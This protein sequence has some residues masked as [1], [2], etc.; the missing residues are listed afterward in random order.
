[1]KKLSIQDQ[2]KK[3]FLNP[4]GTVNKSTVAAF[5]TLLILLVQQVLAIFGAKFTG[6][7]S[8]IA[9]AINTVLAILAAAGFVEGSGEVTTTGG[10]KNAEVSAPEKEQTG[11]QGK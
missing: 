1:M 3:K 4:D 8:Q 10:E 6:D 7:W 9:G 11:V 2:V 5:I